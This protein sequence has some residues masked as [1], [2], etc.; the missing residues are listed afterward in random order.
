MRIVFK[1]FLIF[2]ALYAPVYKIVFSFSDVP[3]TT[4][5]YVSSLDCLTLIVQS[6]NPSTN[7]LLS[8][9]TMD[10]PSPEMDT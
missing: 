5:N 1:L 6:I 8:A 7:S 2:T 9:V 10:S 4:A 3:E